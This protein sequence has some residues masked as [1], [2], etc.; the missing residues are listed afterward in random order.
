M[1]EV[2]GSASGR[3]PIDVIAEWV[4]RDAPLR[5]T[6]S[7]V[8]GLTSPLNAKFNDVEV[9]LTI[10]EVGDSNKIKTVRDIRNLVW[11]KMPAQHKR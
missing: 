9:D 3:N 7:G 8:R 6:D 4:L 2:I 10:A 11:S 1:T 5:F